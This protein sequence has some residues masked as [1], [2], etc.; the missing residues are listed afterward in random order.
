M[1]NNP[2]MQVMILAA[3]RSTRLGSLGLTLPK[4]LL[5][6]CGYPAVTYAL[7]LCR[8]AGLH[9]V[10]INLHHHG[11][12]IGRT[13]GDGSQFGVNLRYSVEE[14]LLGTGGGVGKARSLFHSEPVLII[15]GKVAADVDLRA[16]I[17]THAEAPRGTVA[18]MVLREDRHPELWA[19]IGVD[20]D[21][22]VR[23][24]RGQR[25]S[26]APAPLAPR[27]FTGIHVVEAGLLDRLPAGVSDLIG[28]AYIPALRA[29]DRI[30]SMT[31]TGYFAEHSTPE[32]Y[33][34]GN[35]ALV[36]NPALLS[37]PPGPLAGV[38]PA[39]QIDP[40]A[41][42]VA[43]VRL[44]AGAVIEAGAVVGPWAVVCGGGRVSAGAQ[45][46]RSVVWPGAIAQGNLV[47][48]IVSPEGPFI[49]ETTPPP[50]MV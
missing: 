13:L 9:D 46:V 23:S 29:G 31:M 10:V 47:G 49:G 7:A 48:A 17:A 30:A 18:T 28:D 26:A 14:E 36:A 8:Q 27:M 35:L 11:D 50:V 40:A 4:P 39:A 38:D 22:A 34:A 32:S 41:S 43:P 3:G 33:L 20:A 25:A 37:H 21:G 15:N 16:V 45:V 6:V 44:A 12:K 2:P 42:I 1:W 5:P 19:P 24:I